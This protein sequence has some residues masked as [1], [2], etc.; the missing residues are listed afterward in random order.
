MRCPQCDSRIRMIPLKVIYHLD[1]NG[2][3]KYTESSPSEY[4]QG[5][6]KC[7]WCITGLEKYLLHD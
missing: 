2:L 7:C 6:T 4:L 1:E 5:C 3:I